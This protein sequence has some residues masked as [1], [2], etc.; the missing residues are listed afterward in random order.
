RVAGASDLGLRFKS[1][2]GGVFKVFQT[3]PQAGGAADD[4]LLLSMTGSSGPG[5][6]TGGGSGGGSARKDVLL[7]VDGGTFSGA[8]GY[9]SGVNTAVF[10][11]RLTPPSYPATLNTIQIYFGNRSNGLAAN[12]PISLIVGTNSSGSASF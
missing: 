6:G 11:N 4:V 3:T 10:V 8:V 7:Q 1:I 2:P 9:P 12:S 5:G